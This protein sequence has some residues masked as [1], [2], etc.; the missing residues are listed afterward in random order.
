MRGKLR[1][2]SLPLHLHCFSHRNNTGPDVRNTVYAHQAG[3]AFSDPTKPSFGV[4]KALAPT[5]H[6]DSGGKQGSGNA[7]VLI[8]FNL[9]SFEL[10]GDFFTSLEFKNRMIFYA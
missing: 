8:S 6:F 9:L 3:A 4:I 5:E 1:S 10:K 7:F 2:L